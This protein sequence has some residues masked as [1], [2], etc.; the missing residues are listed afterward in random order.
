MEK[1]KLKMAAAGDECTCTPAEV[2]IYP[3]SGGSNVRIC[4]PLHRN[5][6]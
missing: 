3:C 5:I 6:M 4:F 1:E 2:L